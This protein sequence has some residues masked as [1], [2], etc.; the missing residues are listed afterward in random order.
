MIR[1]LPSGSARII[2]VLTSMAL[3]AG[4]AAQSFEGDVIDKVTQAPLAGAYITAFC[5]ANPPVAI[6]DAFGHFVLA[7][8]GS[9]NRLCNN[10]SVSRA[11]YLRRN[12]AFAES[13]PGQPAPKLRIAL[14]P[15]AVIAGKILDEDGFPVEGAQVS[16]LRYRIVDGERKLEGWMS[17][18]NRQSND[19]GEYRLGGLRPGKYYVRVSNTG[20]AGRWDETYVP[21]FYPAAATAEEATL[22]ELKAGDQRT[23]IHF[24][25]VRRKGATVEGR[26]ALPDGGT[27]PQLWVH[28]DSTDDF[29][30][31][32]SSRFGVRPDGSFTISHVTPG[33]YTLNVQSGSGLAGALGGSLPV[34]VG[35]TDVRD[36]LVN[37]HKVEPQ[38]VAGK[39]TYQGDAAQRPAKVALRFMDGSVRD[40]PIDEDGSFLIKAVS[41]GY[42]TIHV[43]P[44]ADGAH[45]GEMMFSLG[46]GV[47]TPGRPQ[48]LELDGGPVEPLQIAVKAPEAVAQTS[49]RVVDA[50]GQPAA[51]VSLLFVGSAPEHRSMAQ[52]D[53]AG[54]KEK[55]G[56]IPDQYR[57][58]LA[59]DE[60]SF[61][62]LDDPDLLAAHANDFPPV[63]IVAGA[64]PPIVLTLHK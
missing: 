6:T 30:V 13:K 55:F 52:T 45:Y 3:A 14:T 29:M 5:G 43:M 31:H 1:P 39:A 62:S 11:G 19:L 63:R 50:T 2:A 53:S 40:A 38:D 46:T 51:G 32:F 56:L 61:D 36:L 49:L 10:F 21:Q 12:S 58:Y 27:A 48:Q 41:P 23:D 42:V 24:H 57:V 37:C 20:S 64:N 33:N 18:L 25:L 8:A 59:D 34:T 44:V 15:Q 17:G 47:R 60:F 9:T 28:L 16:I 54:V 35:Q 7:D 22:L 26:L 4:L